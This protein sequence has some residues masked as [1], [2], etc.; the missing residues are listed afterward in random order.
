MPLI[1]LTLDYVDFG[2]LDLW[3]YMIVIWWEMVNEMF[4]SRACSSFGSPGLVCMLGK[5]HIFIA[6]L[7]QLEDIRYQLLLELTRSIDVETEQWVSFILGGSGVSVYGKRKSH[8][9]QHCSVKVR[10]LLGKGWG[11][12]H[13]FSV[14]TIEKSSCGGNTTGAFTKSCKCYS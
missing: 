4:D 13:A 6:K 14:F 5:Q 8:M 10:C 3:R 2:L 9:L 1:P 12:S 11:C 7:S